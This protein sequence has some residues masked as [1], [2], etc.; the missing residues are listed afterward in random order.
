[1]TDA[2]ETPDW[3]ALAPWVNRRLSLLDGRLQSLTPAETLVLAQQLSAAAAEAPDAKAVQS[4]VS[5]YLKHAGLQR[6]DWSAKP[7]LHALPMLGCGLKTGLCLIHGRSPQSNLWV[8]ETA[9]GR[10]EWES[11]PEDLSF[12]SVALGWREKLESGALAVFATVLMQYKKPLVYFALASLVINL[13]AL[14]TSLYSM[15][16]YDRVIPSRGV[17]TLVVLTVGVAVTII[18]ELVLKFLRSL[19]MDRVVQNADVELSHR[20]FERLMSVRMD[21][22]PASVGTLASQLRSYE[23]IRGFAYSATTYLLIDT[24]FAL[25]FMVLIFIIGGPV[26]AAIPLTFFLVALILGLT[27]KRKTEQHT[28]ESQASSNRKLG[29]L[30]EAVD[31]AETI[32]AQGLRWHF[33]NRWNALTQQ[34]VSEDSKVRHINEA[35]SYY[36]ATL[37]QLSYVLLVATGAYV[38][39]TTNDLTS[40]G[41]IAC[42][43]LSGRV[44][45]PVTML[46]GLLTQWANSKS[47][48]TG[49]DAIFKLQ[50][51]HHDAQSPLPLTAAEGF[52]ELDN[53][54][55]AYP[56]QLQSV[57]IPK[58]EVK[59]GE[60]IGI[61]GGIGSGKS[62]FLKLLAGLYKPGE[63]RVL[64][65][66]L[67]LQHIS[68]SHVSQHIGVVSQNVQLFAG[69]LKDNLVAGLIGITEEAVRQACQATGLAAFVATHPKGL[70]MPIAEGGGGVSG[71]QRQL[72]G[73]T[74]LLL[75]RPAV[76]LLD[77]P[78]SS[79]DDETERRTLNVLAGSV[80][81]NQT[82]VLVTHKA[83]V[84]SLVSRLVVMAGG[85]IVLDGPRDVVLE[86]LRNASKAAA[87]TAAQNSVAVQGGSAPPS[88]HPNADGSATATEPSHS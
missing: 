13:L 59:P 63:G 50:L 12:C 64:F 46:P 24:P 85:R 80:A 48:L 29:L 3:A 65:D 52:Y 43:I 25:V 71:G 39:S 61:I 56:G 38:A 57:Q 55:F 72:I 49:I 73:L 86:H 44:L 11:L 45:Q 35:S 78:T 8:A 26:V 54:V 79:M 4:V 87:Q 19:M 21:Q 31:G 88:P 40:G 36:A 76:W 20:I 23:L 32:K 42:S 68:R 27:F 6:A 2:L 30:V 17:E 22:F 70:D 60:K 53:V 9:K 33:L 58:W 74:R 14:L 69:T 28:R 18:F 7:K 62:T 47:A 1:M 67:D 84:L 37:Q 82:L 16:V 77:E 81:A 83:S 51:D 10:V 41:L 34:N 15:Q 75:T 5:T 66:H